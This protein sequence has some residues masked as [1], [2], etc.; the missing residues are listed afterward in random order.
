M[1][2][3]SK[4]CCLEEAK[5]RNYSS[6]H[7]PA[8]YRARATLSTGREF[9][10]YLCPVHMLHAWELA[11][12]LMERG[13]GNLEAEDDLRLECISFHQLNAFRRSTSHK[14]PSTWAA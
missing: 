12:V 6:C 2:Y 8:K 7:E 5:F 3:N 14:K 1:S 13:F 4:I 10:L 11:Q 9:V